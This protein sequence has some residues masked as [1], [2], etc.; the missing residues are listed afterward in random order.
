TRGNAYTRSTERQTFKAPSKSR[1]KRE[2]PP[3]PPKPSVKSICTRTSYLT[4]SHIPKWDIK[5]V[6]NWFTAEP[7]V[8]PARPAPQP[9]W[10]ITLSIGNPLANR[11]CEAG[12]GP[13]ANCRRNLIG[14]SCKVVLGRG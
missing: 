7:L 4:L 13:F 8:D 12:L 3:K 1:L 14:T 11:C 5:I 9:T 10:S 2:I 6:C